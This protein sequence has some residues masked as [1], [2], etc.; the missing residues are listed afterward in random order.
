MLNFF[1]INKKKF[2]FLEKYKSQD[3]N[4]IQNKI[5]NDQNL[6]GSIRYFDDGLSRI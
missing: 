3:Q 2:N 6:F 4:K 1:A 5:K